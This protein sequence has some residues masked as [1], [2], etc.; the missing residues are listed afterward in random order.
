MLW[1]STSDTSVRERVAFK[2]GSTSSMMTPNEGVASHATSPPGSFL[3]FNMDCRATSAILVKM[4][5]D[6]TQMAGGTGL[7]SLIV[8][9]H[10]VVLYCVEDLVSAF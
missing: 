9:E 6:I 8:L 4:V 2:N 3:R 5:D 10:E 1:R 7:M